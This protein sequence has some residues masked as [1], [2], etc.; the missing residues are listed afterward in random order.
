[1]SVR[2]LKTGSFE[3]VWLVSSSC[4]KD[5]GLWGPQRANSAGSDSAILLL[6]AR[7]KRC[8][9]CFFPRL[10]FLVPPTHPGEPSWT[11]ARPDIGALLIV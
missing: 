3:V 9:R 7:E 8:S 5:V 2:F 11:F 1:M 4:G 6:H 10:V